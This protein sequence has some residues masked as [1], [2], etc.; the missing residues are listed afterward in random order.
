MRQFF[1][2]FLFL[3]SSFPATAQNNVTI[4]GQVFDDKHKPVSG[5]VI[6]L[7]NTN[8]TVTS[9]ADGSFTISNIPPGTYNAIISAFGFA[10]RNLVL[11][12]NDANARTL[13]IIVTEQVNK[14]DDVIVSTQKREESIQRIPVSVTALSSKDVADYRLW[15]IKDISGISPATYSANPGDGRN[16]TSIRGIA[17]TSYDPAVTTYIDGVSQFTLDTYIP[18]LFDVERVE[19]ARG[20]QGTL[21]GRNAMGGVINIITKQ[22]ANTVSGFAEA[23]VGN[24]GMQRYTAGLRVPVIKN[25][26]FFGAAGMFT[27]RNGFYKNELNGN[28]F[29]NQQGIAG[30][31]YLKFIPTSQWAISLNFKH[32]LNHNYGAFPLT[33]GV[34][35]ALPDPFKLSQDATARMN[36]NTIN[37][38][39]SISHTGHAVNFSSQ[40]AWQQNYRYYNAPLDADFSPIDAVTLVNNF[41]GDW[42]K[43]KVITEELRFTS[44]ARESK[45]TWLGGA[46]FFHLDNP[47]KQAI[48]YGEDAG[49]LGLPDINFS[50]INTAKAKSTGV[51]LF[52]Q[53]TYAI[54]K[55]V[56]ITGGLRFDY[57]QK[58]LLVHGDYQKDGEQAFVI[59]PDTTASVDFNAV[60]PH[61]GLSY[62]PSASTQVFITYSRGFRTGGLTQLSQDPSQPPLYPY[63]PEYS[64]TVEAGIK[65]SLLNNKLTL[66]ASA[67]Y[68]YVRDVQVP[69]LVLPDAI[70]ITKNTGKLTA[71]G[72]ELQ[73][74]AAPA[75]GLQI[76]YNFG[77]T[78]AI[79]NSLKIAQNGETVNLDD[80]KQ[81]FTPD[82][83]SM[84]A[85]QYTCILGKENK[86]RLVIRGEWLYIG[87]QYFDLA[88]TITQNAY[89]L[90][91]AKLGVS[92][93][94]AGLYFWARNIANKKYVAYA[95]D[96]GAVHLG[97]P[98]TFGATLSI[99]FRK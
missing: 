39:L 32:Q 48:H 86:C 99:R 21:Y 43:V 97:D 16:V 47:G 46:Y 54:T 26:L 38:S 94:T 80:K 51:A 35:E 66:N 11:N 3:L 34:D 14:L 45:L 50:T 68:T 13:T 59:Q 25:K 15:D 81:L 69:T 8:I 20:P 55:Q 29:D 12:T 52:G 95:Y 4:T 87:R 83:T 79:Y 19:I 62:F 56:A 71:T 24:H 57:E 5:A 92:S 61:I 60:S 82:I 18:N 30:N 90:L 73:L 2:A 31:Y 36:D 98:G 63:K 53:L 64:N 70:T 9:G 72:L 28:T 27:S 77:Y 1:Y 58:E 37:A 22:P 33:Y 75:K 91:N 85:A 67:F 65:N 93:K 23:S 7:L 10:T 17:T 49:M 78:H 76:D 74:A 42:N 96:F 6:Y 89:G 41:G 44:P 84:L 40:T 88:N